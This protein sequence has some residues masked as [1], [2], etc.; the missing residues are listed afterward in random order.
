M[1]LRSLNARLRR[2]LSSRPSK[3]SGKRPHPAYR[4]RLALQPLE[5]RCLLDAWGFPV[6]NLAN[7]PALNPSSVAVGDF[8][9]DGKPD[10]VV[11]NRVSNNLSVFLG[12]GDGT[13]QAAVTYNTGSQPVFVAVGDFNSDGKLDLVTANFGNNTVSVLLGNG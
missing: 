9:H 8:N 6:L 1:A 12:N 7:A 4:G 2:L 10:L 5:E 3:R 11:A 13:F